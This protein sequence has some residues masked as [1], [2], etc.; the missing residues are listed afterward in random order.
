M[1]L[2]LYLKKKNPNVLEHDIAQIA[3]KHGHQVLFSCPYN[4]NDMPSEYLNSYVK[5]M[6]KKR[7]KKHRTIL[8]LKNDIRDGFSFMV[9]KQEVYKFM[10]LSIQEWPNDGLQNVNII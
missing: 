3:K 1:Y 2:F 8:E 6:V 9:E 4:P 7:C 5:L 10:K